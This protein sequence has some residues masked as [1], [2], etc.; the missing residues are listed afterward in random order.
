[1]VCVVWV[2]RVLKAWAGKV[3]GQRWQAVG[4]AGKWWGIAVKA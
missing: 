3:L 2:M 1:M 4:K